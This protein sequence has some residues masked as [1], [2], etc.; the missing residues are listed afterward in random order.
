MNLLAKFKAERR[1][2]MRDQIGK[3][4]AWLEGKQ[5]FVLEALAK[6]IPPER[7]RQ[8]LRDTGRESRRERRLPAVWTVYF[9]IMMGLYRRI[10][11]VNLLEKLVGTAWS[12]DNWDDGEPPCSSAV[13]K[14]RDRLGIQP[15]Q[16]LFE[17][18]SQEWAASSTGY[19]CRGKR[20][21]ALDGTTVKTADTPV[22]GRKFHKPAASRGRS[23]YPQLRVLT[24]SDVGTRLIR[25]E[26][27]GSYHVSEISMARDILP[28]V[29]PGSIVVLDR[30][31]LAYDFLWAITNARQAD[32]VLRL[33]KDVR[34]RLI[35]RIGKGDEIVE[36]AIP[37]QCRRL[38]KYI[39]RTW[40]LRLITFVP[41]GG[42]EVIRLLTSLTDETFTKGEIAALYHE[43]WEEETITDE[44]KTHLCDCATVNRPVAF[45]S[46]TPARVEQEWYGLLIAYNVLRLLMA[47]AATN[48]Q[49]CPR[50][51][52]FTAALERLREAIWDMGRM[53]IERLPSRYREMLKAMARNRVPMRPDRHNPRAVKIKMSAYA[54]KRSRRVA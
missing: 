23:A 43:R 45:R 47:E 51:I 19:C 41:K 44:L 16:E 21:Y 30:N 50:R 17:H 22:N 42:K 12:K 11:Y 29:A 53:Q 49:V 52:S 32:F 35:K 37:P 5:D 14:A 46:Q 27:H 6:A 4:A 20:V 3:P 39:P 2:P 40:R 9:T 31:F 8:V 34:P 15:L 28:Q 10:S 33:R 7:I 38:H 26:R 18:C 13:S 36:V 24:L 48:V 1:G 54:L 25:A